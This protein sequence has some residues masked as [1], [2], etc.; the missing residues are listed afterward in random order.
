[1][2]K[3]LYEELSYQIRSVLY[4]VYNTLGPGFKEEASVL[5][6]KSVLSVNKNTSA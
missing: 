4:E 6:V 1:M 3:L 2:G 5:S